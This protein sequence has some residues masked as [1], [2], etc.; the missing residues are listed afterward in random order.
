[1][2]ELLL[3]RHAK[4]S[5]AEAG[6]AD[7]SRPLNERGRRAAQAMGRTISAKSLLPEVALCS[8][9]RRARETWEIAAAELP[10]IPK[11]QITDGMYDFGNGSSLLHCLHISGLSARRIIM[12]GHNPSMEGL[13]SSLTGSGDTKLI[14]R[15]DK[16]YPTGALAALRFQVNDWR[17]VAEK[18]GKL[19][20]FIRPKDIMPDSGGD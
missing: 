12:V 2:L 8:P 11:L 19:I 1:M 17:D 10:R 16:K 13:A 15:M 6:A 3:L 18:T 9:A 20:C 4:S 5:L 14:A 7:I